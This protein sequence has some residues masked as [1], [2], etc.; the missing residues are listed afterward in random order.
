MEL[1]QLPPAPNSHPV[2][3]R[4]PQHGH[5]NKRAAKGTQVVCNF[6]RL[7]GDPRTNKQNC[8]SAVNKATSFTS[9]SPDSTVKEKIRKKKNIYIY[10]NTG[11]V[12]QLTPDGTQK[13]PS[14]DEKDTESGTRRRH[15]KTAREQQLRNYPPLSASNPYRLKLPRNKQLS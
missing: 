5:F 2:P 12:F 4:P 11:T 8:S 7:W 15:P 9:R 10:I 6:I 1:A 3:R 14:D 13:G